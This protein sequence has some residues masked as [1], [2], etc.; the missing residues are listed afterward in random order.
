MDMMMVAASQ[1]AL[2]GTQPGMVP[3]HGA[4]MGPQT[5]LTPVSQYHNVAPNSLPQYASSAS[6]YVTAPAPPHY[7]TSSH[8]HQAQGASQQGPPPP[9]GVPHQYATAP[10]P[11]QTGGQQANQQPPAPAFVPVSTTFATDAMGQMVL[12]MTPG[13]QPLQLAMTQQ[14]YIQVTLK[15]G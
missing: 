11:Y 10:Q 5:Y 3:P 9:P 2:Q 14:A 8:H 1:G 12:Q 7:V 6:Q 15:L 13:Q 4:P